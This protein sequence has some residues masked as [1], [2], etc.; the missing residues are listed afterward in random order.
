MFSPR[1]KIWKLIDFN[2]SLPVEESL[3]TKRYVGTRGFIA[4]ESKATG[5]YTEKSDIYSL[6]EV[7]RSTFGS[8]LSKEYER[9]KIK[10]AQNTI[11]IM[12]FKKLTMSMK[13][14]DPHDRVS[15]LDALSEAFSFLNRLLKREAYKSFSV[16]GNDNLLPEVKRTLS[17]H[18]QS[19]E[20]PLN[21][22]K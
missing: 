2:Y 3:V 22:I 6:G 16:Y 10:N 14:F 19:D 15:V 18:F 1:S 7:I 17:N 9:S 5:I 11:D 20:I 21:K 13:E 4:P 8:N 12:D